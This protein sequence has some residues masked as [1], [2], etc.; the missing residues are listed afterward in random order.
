MQFE[1]KRNET[2][3]RERVLAILKKEGV[4]ES[5]YNKTTIKKLCEFYRFDLR[6]ILNYLQ[7]VLQKSTL[8]KDS[9]L[10][11][12]KHDLGEQTSYFDV[13]QRV[14]FRKKPAHFWSSKIEDFRKYN[15]L[16]AQTEGRWTAE[17]TR[18]HNNY[19][20][21]KKQTL[22]PFTASRTFKSRENENHKEYF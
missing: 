14:L 10:A 20:E 21:E 13:M 7:L 1:F 8:N 16:K 2:S 11:E 3:I 19:F 9:L 22:A 4:D 18:L 12:L 15:R 17:L 5:L 6:A